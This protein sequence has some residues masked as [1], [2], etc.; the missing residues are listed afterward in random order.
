MGLLLTISMTWWE[1]GR[2]SM[3]RHDHHTAGSP[4][5]NKGTVHVSTIKTVHLYLITNTSGVSRKR[6]VYETESDRAQGAFTGFAP[7]LPTRP[8]GLCSLNFARLHVQ[9]RGGDPLIHH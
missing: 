5:R 4:R 9:I 7:S 1:D 2:L 3:G 6:V 8:K